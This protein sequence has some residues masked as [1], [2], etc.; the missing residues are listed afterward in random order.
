MTNEEETE[1]KGTSKEP[2]EIKPDPVLKNLLWKS[3]KGGPINGS[4]ENNINSK[5]EIKWVG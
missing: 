4:T 3:K 5:S 2:V 1:T